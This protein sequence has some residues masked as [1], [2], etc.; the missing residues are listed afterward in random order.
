MEIRSMTGFGRAEYADAVYRIS[1]EVKS[2][3][4]R[5]LDLNIRMPKQFNANESNI[6]KV[7]KDY[8]TRGKMDLFINYEAFSGGEQ[9][10]HLNLSLAG[11]YLT[12]IRKLASEYS[13]QDNASVMSIATMPDVL[14]LSEE[15]EDDAL[16]F[17][18]LEPVLRQALEMFVENRKREGENLQK[19]LLEKLS[20][21]EQIV[22]RIDDRA[23]EIVAAYEKKL[24]DKV[25]ELLGTTGIDENRIVEEVT[26][27]SDKVCTDEERVR[28][29]SHIK[30]MEKKLIDGGSVGRELDFLAQEMNREANTTLSKAQDLVT[31]DD[32]IALK[33]L[34]EKIREQVQNIE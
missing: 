19:D 31:A 14:S 11:E 17:G 23:P 21:M 27:Y 2:V 8:V 34:I 20:E 3:N 15:S 32:A 4:S 7:L 29:H 9:S 1:V 25:A 24:H 6:R 26:I 5:F 16:L 18:R 22:G 33:T 10:V 12:A 13:L 30:N 28:L